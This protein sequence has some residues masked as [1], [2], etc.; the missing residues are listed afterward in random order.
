MVHNMY[1]LHYTSDVSET[2]N[3]FL[4]CRRIFLMN[5]WR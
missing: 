1:V 2:T 4:T 5:K 3:I